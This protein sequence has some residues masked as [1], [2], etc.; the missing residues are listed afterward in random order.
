MLY[1]ILLT[2]HIIAGSLALLGAIIAIY[3]KIVNG[4]HQW[5]I[6]GGLSFFYGM[7]FVFLTTV[8]MTFLKP[9][10]FLFLIGIF[11]FYFAFMGWRMA[12]NRTGNAGVPEYAAIII[13]AITAAVMTV[14]GGNLLWNDNGNGVTL[15]I[16]G[17]IGGIFAISSYRRY[18]TGPIKGK[19]RIGSHLGNMLGAT[20][21]A[22]TAVLVVNVDTEPV[23]L[24]WIAPTIVI[25]PL[26][27]WMTNRVQKGKL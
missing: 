17:A 3:T 6:Y 1:N 19:E 14:W 4:S 18:Q 9:N 24:V 22:V 10:L 23:W 7:L 5:H 15:I 13:M 8:P 26:I 27:F 21:A 20:I 12:V 11:S 2:V 25:T 16:F